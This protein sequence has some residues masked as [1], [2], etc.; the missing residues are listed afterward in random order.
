MT[1]SPAL[2]AHVVYRFGIGGLENGVVNL[3]N[4]LPASRWRHA[5]IA[6][7]SVD[8]AMRAR[9]TRPDVEY[10][11]LDKR[12]GH[13]VPYYPRLY[14]LFRRLQ[15]SVVHTR[16]LAA[17]EAVVPARL[18]GVG[19]VVHGEHGRDADDIE[20]RNARYRLVRRAYSPFVSRYV[21]LSLDLQR[22][23]VDGVGIAPGRISQLYNGVDCAAFA[24][25]GKGRALLA[26]GPFN[27]P[28]LF[29][30]GTVGRLDAVKDQ[31]NLARAFVSALRRHPQAR[32]RLRLVIVGD[33]TLRGDVQRI[34]DD[35][36]ASALAWLPGARHDVAAVMRALDCFVL[37]SLSE[38]ISN[39]LLEAMASG[40]PVVATRVGGNAELMEEGLTGRLVPRA[41]PEALA[42]EILRYFDHP[43]L[44]RR[45]GRAG[46]DLAEKRFSIE[47]MVRRYDELYSQVLRRQGPAAAPVVQAH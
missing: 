46:R 22:Y 37:P 42:T 24:P 29:V 2:I 16:N 43:Q 3:I 7:T 33:G 30:I 10:V 11:A 34:L 44:A 28:R 9:V 18:A 21:A 45:H 47:Q 13:L 32:E 35:A 14:R 19:A 31:T 38:G 1:T 15:P 20:G 39:T 36:D 4:R 6:L 25:G 27:D 41:D 23:L 17:L 40:L 5:V 26:D 8:E 12:P